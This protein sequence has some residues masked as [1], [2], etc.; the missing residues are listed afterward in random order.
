M[1]NNKLI[2]ELDY[3]NNNG[4]VKIPA[5]VSTDYQKLV[6]ALF[7]SYGYLVKSLSNGKRSNIKV[8][9]QDKDSVPRH[10]VDI[11]REKKSLASSLVSN[12]DIKKI[13]HKFFK[14]NKRYY[15]TH[16]K[17][18]FKTINKNTSWSP[19]Q[20]NGYKLFSNKDGFAIFICLED[21]DEN[22]GALQ[23]YS[24]SH[25]LGKLYHTKDFE[26]ISTQ[27]QYIIPNQLLPDK[28]SLIS[29]NAKKGDIIIFHPNCIHQ[30]GQSNSNSRRLALIFEVEEYFSFTTD[31]YGKEPIMIKGKINLLERILTLIFS[32]FSL[33]RFWITLS[34]YPMIKKIIRILFVYPLEIIY[35]K[36][37][38]IFF[39]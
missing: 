17:L 27:S 20:D 32:I 23:V 29:L 19:H 6:D 34:R 28:S 13:I 1:K 30:S 9:F 33:D 35:Q 4:Y 31:D 14:K 15:I 24:K 10:I 5:P 3:Y 12:I 25:L 36:L 37:S 16:S 21:M 7:Q 8:A 2:K 22:N 11:L 18:S 39:K 38:F 26:T